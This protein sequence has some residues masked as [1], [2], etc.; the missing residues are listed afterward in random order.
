MCKISV[1]VI[2]NFVKNEDILEEKLLYELK[3]L[4]YCF[5]KQK[6]KVVDVLIILKCVI[7][8]IIFNVLFGVECLYDDE[9]FFK[10]FYFV[11]NY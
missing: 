6:G 7:V 3:C 5:K 2:Y 9:G 1:G 8:N 11:E 10:I 4:V